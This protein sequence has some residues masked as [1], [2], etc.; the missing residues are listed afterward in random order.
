MALP[1]A[2]QQ[3]ELSKGLKIIFIVDNLTKN[4]LNYDCLG[5][6]SDKYPSSLI[7]TNPASTISGKLLEK[8]HSQKIILG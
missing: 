2:V 6:A 8:N 4:Y 1:E 3:E 7:Y 5:S